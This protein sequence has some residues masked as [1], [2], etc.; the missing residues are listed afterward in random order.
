[1]TATALTM[2]NCHLTIPALYFRGINDMYVRH[3]RIQHG[4]GQGSFHSATVEFSATGRHR[5]DYVFDCGALK[6]A[7]LS[8]E[9][10]YALK[11]VSL[12]KRAP[13]GNKAV[14][15]LMVLS[16]FDADHMNGAQSLVKR[17]AVDR[18]VLPYLGVEELA[19]IIASQADAIDKDTLK[20][21]HGLANGVGKLWKRPVTMVKTG[22]RKTEERVFSDDP[23]RE[24]PDAERSEPPRTQEFPHPVSVVLES[25][26]AAPGTV[27]LDEDNLVVGSS[28][29]G[30][31]D[32]WK[33]RFWNRG[34]HA[35]LGE[36]GIWQDFERHYKRELPQTQTVVVPHHGAAPNAG[37]RFYNPG[38][39]HRPRVNAVISYAVRNSHGH[40]HPSVL[41]DIAYAGG[42]LLRVT[43]DTRL[44]YQEIYLFRP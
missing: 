4:V 37:A 5:F 30:R 12:T 28:S 13:G 36:P 33:L 26:G 2:L 40:P 41:A 15:D 8:P 3:S 22:P 25:T 20:E 42:R 16:H 43:D 17:Y 11:R 27:M 32:T 35:T 44:G 14:L 23:Q 6:Y 19:L 10:Q 18:I 34:L 29:A 31:H 7:K 38:L 1:M 24:P 9:F 39:N 21:L